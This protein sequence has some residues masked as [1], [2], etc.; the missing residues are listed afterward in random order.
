MYFWWLLVLAIMEYESDDDLSLAG[1]TQESREIQIEISLMRKMM[2]GV[3]LVY[4]WIWQENWLV[5]VQLKWLIL[6]TISMTL[7]SHHKFHIK[8][9]V[10]EMLQ[11]G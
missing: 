6:T 11:K 3:T 2:K 7:V 8:V 5:V 4:F 1:L 9:K 10:M